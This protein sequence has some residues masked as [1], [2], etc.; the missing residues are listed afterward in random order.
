MSGCLLLIGAEGVKGLDADYADNP[1]EDIGLL[2]V[3][4]DEFGRLVL[5]VFNGLTNMCN[6]EVGR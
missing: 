4:V 3:D 1:A 5:Y 2:K 6:L